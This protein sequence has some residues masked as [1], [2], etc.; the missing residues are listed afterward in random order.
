M[1][2]NIEMLDESFE[3]RLD[4]RFLLLCLIEI[5]DIIP[6]QSQGSFCFLFAWQQ[7]REKA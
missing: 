3:Y 1:K 4:V 2:K 6:K 5:I 7:V